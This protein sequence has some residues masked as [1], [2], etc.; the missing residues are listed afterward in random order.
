MTL[1]DVLRRLRGP[2]NEGFLALVL[3]ALTVGMSIKNPSFLS[4]GTLYQLVFNSMVPLIFALCVLMVIIS[5]GIDV[6]FGAVAIFSAYTTVRILT[7]GNNTGGW[8][9]LGA[10]AM[11][12]IIGA[13]LGLVNGVIIARFRMPTLIATLGTQSIFK[14]VMVSWVGSQYIGTIPSSMDALSGAA[15]FRTSDGYLHV[16]LIP[17][18]LL[19]VFISLLSRKTMFGRSIFAIGGDQEAARRVGFRVVRSQVLLYVMVG[20]MAAIGGMI[21]VILGRNAN[22]QTLV[23]GELDVI[24]AVVLGG[25]S[26]FGGRGSVLGTILGVVLIQVIKNSLL[27]IGVPTAWQRA[28]VGALLLIGVSI[29]AIA[30]KQ[31]RKAA[32][33][34]HEE[35]AA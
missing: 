16:L 21:Y 14:G 15:I 31:A 13:G 19:A 12:M 33:T 10:F 23:G 5:G 11:A 3:I 20:M 1:K 8:L 4:L 7:S 22:P 17:V 2:N 32:T 26:I 29:Q 18:I 30:A 34:K 28:A 27:L 24:A 35:V 25:A 6:S 9:A